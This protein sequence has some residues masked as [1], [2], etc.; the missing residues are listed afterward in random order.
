MQTDSR[1]ILPGLLSKNSEVLLD[2][3]LR[4]HPKLLHNSPELAKQLLLRRYANNLP[5]LRGVMA[6]AL[7]VDRNPELL[8]VK[9]PNAPQHDVYQ[10]VNGRR[11][12][13]NGQVKFHSSGD[14]AVYAR[15]MGKDYRRT[16]SLFLTI[17]LLL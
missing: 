15:D 5:Q 16:G 12:P 11:T 6:E 3:L 17:M 10:W 9:N 14:P 2:A 8:Y 7:C 4:K 13:F 1:P